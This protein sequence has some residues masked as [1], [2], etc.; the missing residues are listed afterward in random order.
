MAADIITL[1]DTLGFASATILGHSMGGK[2][3]MSCALQY[4]ERIQSLIIA[5]IAPVTYEHEFETIIAAQKALPLD[6]LST[7]VEADELMSTW[8]EQPMLR[9]FLLQNLVKSTEGYQWRINLPVIDEQMPV[10]TAFPEIPVDTHFDKATLFLRGAQSNYVLEK[11]HQTIYQ[12]FPK[13]TIKTIENC[14]HWLHA[15][16]AEL[17]YQSTVDFLDEN[18][19]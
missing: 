10:I 8:I 1:L 16:Q 5:D 12:R 17:F 9:Q 14:G 13:A 6:Q 11:H 2:V 3:A 18:A 4:P 19:K 7:R 15:E